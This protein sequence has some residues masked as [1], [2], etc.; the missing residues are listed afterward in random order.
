M[1]ESFNLYEFIAFAIVVFISTYF[2]GTFIHEIVG[3]EGFGILGN[4]F[5]LTA[6]I[7]LGLYVSAEYQ[8]PQRDYP[9][10]AVCGVAGGFATLSTLILAKIGLR[11]LGM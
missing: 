9:I 8:I 3:A 11:K 4:A 7:F 5:V 2:L 1:L 10:L 6:G